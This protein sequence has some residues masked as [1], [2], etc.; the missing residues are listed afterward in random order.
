MQ[1]ATYGYEIQVGDVISI[2]SGITGTRMYR[3]VRVTSKYAFV[4]YNDVAEGKFQRVYQMMFAKL[5]RIKF[6]TRQY[7]VYTNA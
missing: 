2:T 3:V 5:P 6:D 7:E 1:K 4:K